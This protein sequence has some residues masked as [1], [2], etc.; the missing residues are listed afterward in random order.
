MAHYMAHPLPSAST[1]AQQ[2]HYVTYTAP[3]PGLHPFSVTLLEAPALLASS[4]TTGFRTWEASLHLASFLTSAEGRKYVT[5]KSVLELGAG[6]GFLSIFCAM[7]LGGKHVLATDGSEEVVH[8][9]KA[10]LAL[11]DIAGNERIK[12]SGLQWGHALIG[13]VADGR[14]DGRVYDLIIGADVVSQLS[15]SISVNVAESAPDIRRPIY[16]SLGGNTERPL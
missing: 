15:I 13:G 14:K 2:K 16:I 7:H 4:G 11:N 5:H 12:A 8:D 3:V 1:A 9:L 6:T 10:N